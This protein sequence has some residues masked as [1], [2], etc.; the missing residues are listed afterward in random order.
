MECLSVSLALQSKRCKA[1]SFI[2]NGN[3][4]RVCFHTINPNSPQASFQPNSNE[5]AP[6]WVFAVK[7]PGSESRNFLQS[8]SPRRKDVRFILLWNLLSWGKTVFDCYG[9]TCCHG[10]IL[11]RHDWICSTFPLNGTVCMVPARVKT[12]WSWQAITTHRLF[13]WAF[14]MRTP[15]E[16]FSGIQSFLDWWNA[17]ISS[18]QMTLSWDRQNTWFAWAAKRERNCMY[19]F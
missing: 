17:R 12:S 18:L 5:V 4:D 8:W 9:G 3:K 19:W 11:L 10:V 2:E 13:R 6:G 14:S 1:S 16:P 7:K 15:N